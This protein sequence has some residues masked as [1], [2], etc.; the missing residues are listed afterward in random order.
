MNAHHGFG[1]NYRKRTKPTGVRD[2]SDDDDYQEGKQKN[3][4]FETKE[5]SKERFARENHSEIERRR[6]NKMNQYIHELSE[7]VPTCNGL[8]R[9]PDKLTIL[10]MAVSYMRALRGSPPPADSNHKPSFLSDQEL[11]H[12]V[13]EAA[14]G[15]LF[16]VSCNTGKILYVS[17]SVTPVLNQAQNDWID[18][19]FFNVIHPEDIDKIKDQLATEISS[20]TRILDLKTGSVRTD[21]NA[22]GSNISNGS[23]RNFMVRMKC[24]T[25]EGESTENDTHLMEIRNRC[26]QKRIKYKDDDYSVVH[27]TG[28]IGGVD[29]LTASPEEDLLS[30][31]AGLGGDQNGGDLCLVAIGRLEPKSM[32]TSIDLIESAPATEFIT[33]Q[34]LDGRFSFVDQRVTDILGYRPVDLLGKLCYEFY[35]KEDIEHMME[36]FDQVL[37]LKGNQISIQYKFKHMNGEPITMRS[38]CYSFQNPYTEE[39]EYIV[40]SNK[41]VRTK[42]ENTYTSQMGTNNELMDPAKQ[43]LKISNTSSLPTT[44][45]GVGSGGSSGNGE[46][47]ITSVIQEKPGMY[48]YPYR[49]QQ[50]SQTNKEQNVSVLESQ[51]ANDNSSKRKASSSMVRQP[52]LTSPHPSNIGKFSNRISSDNDTYISNMYPEASGVLANMARKH[53]QDEAPSQSQYQIQTDWGSVPSRFQ[54]SDMEISGDDVGNQ[55]PDALQNLYQSGSSRGVIPQPRDLNLSGQDVS[56][57]LFMNTYNEQENT[58]TVYEQNQGLPM[59]VAPLVSHSRIGSY[60]QSIPGTQDYSYQ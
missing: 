27:C 42:T 3:P 41:V 23:R 19:S 9:K 50:G 11:K 34:T 38:T 52:S 26:K 45:A 54:F 60:T 32:P 7:M 58:R 2:G 59:Q 10:K 28:Y 53:Q 35:V 8:I 30:G 14:D 6:R 44:S 20:E 17:D 47:D 40:C 12:L 31:V 37:K 22:S 36:N 51:L 56:S 57:R 24:G 29:H 39:A 15:F 18:A 46:N 13:L 16:I 1:G 25:Y 43:L 55:P 4:R 33:R 21:G 49:I 48:A 5:Q